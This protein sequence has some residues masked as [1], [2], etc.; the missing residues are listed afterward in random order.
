MIRKI[1]YLSFI[2]MKKHFLKV[3][4]WLMGL[5][6]TLAIWVVNA[7]EINKDIVLQATSTAA[8]QTLKI[9]KY[10][11][12]A[13]T[14][15]RWDGSSE[16]LSSDTTHTYATAWTYTITLS[17]TWWAE[18]RRFVYV[19]K[20][21]VPV[22]WTTMTWVKITSMPSL[23]EWFG[24][25]ATNPENYY[26]LRFNADWAITSLPEWSFDTSSITSANNNFFNS[27]NWN[28]Q[29]TS[30]PTWSFNISN[31]T[32]VGT[33]FFENFNK[34][35]SLTVLP[36]WSFDISNITS[37]N[38]YFFYAFNSQ[39][40]LTSLPTW[41]FKLST[42]LTTVGNYFFIL[43][44]YKWALTSLP[45]WSF[46]T[47]NISWSVWSDF[48]YGFNQYWSL[49]SLPE[50]SFNT[51]NITAAGNAFFR[52]FN[53]YWGIKSLPEWSFNISNLMTVWN[54][55]FRY[56]NGYWALESLPEWSFNISN[57]T[58]V[59]TGLFA[60]FNR[61]WAITELPNSF[62]MNSAW[63]ANTNG[64]QNAFNST[65]Y[66][67]N[68]N[69]SDLVSWVTVP[70]SDMDTF[71]DN[72]PWRCGVHENWLVTIADACHIRYDANGWNGS[73]TWWYVANVT[74]V[75]AWSWIAIPIR[76]GYIFDWWTNASWDIVEEVSFP[77]MDGQTLYA[78]WR[79]KD[80]I[81]QATSTAANQKIKINKYFANNYT[82]NRWDGSSTTNASSTN[83][84]TY[85]TAW[86]Y[87]IT[88]SLT[89]WADR[90][91]FNTEYNANPLVPTNGTTMTWVKIT[92]MP[93]LE[94]WFGINATA[95]WTR[96]F[97]NFN[98]NWALTSLPDWSF[99][100]SKITTAGDGFFDCFNRAWKI[101]S[102][103]DWSFNIS[104][105]TTVWNYFMASFNRFWEMT[106]LPT[107]SFILSSWLT[108]ADEYFFSSFN[109]WW[110][111]TS[112]PEWSF[113]TSNITTAKIYFFPSFNREWA[114]TSLP[115]WS[116]DTSNITSADSY[117]F[118]AFNRDWALTNLPDSFNISSK[119]Y[120]KTNVY[121][122]A[123]N[124][125]YT[126]NKRVYDLVNGKTPPSSDQ[127]TFSDN[128]PW[129]CGVHANWLVTT[130]NACNIRYDANGWNGSV[131]WWYAANTTS[132]AAWSGIT[133]PT[134]E[135]YTFSGWLDASW[136]KVD[137]IVFPDMDGQTLYADWT[138]NE[139]TI[140]FID[141]S[142]TETE[143]I[144]TW[145]YETTVTTDYPEWTKEWYTIHWDKG[146]PTTM[147]LSW[148]TITASW[149]I[150][151][152]TITID[153]DGNITT[154]T[155]DYGSPITP[156]ANPT[157]NWYKFVGWEPEIPATMPAKDMTIKAKWEKNW[158]SGWWGGSRNKASDAQDSS[159]KVYT[160]SSASEWHTYTQEFQEAYEFAKEK[161]IT[162]M[163]TIQKAD[164]DGKLTR[165]AM[166]KMLSQYAMNV[167][168]QKPD[169]TINNKFN[170]V[171]D[172]QNS[173]YDDW[174]TL[175]YQLW[176]MWQNMPNNRF[177][178]NDEV[179][180]WEFV[181]A[182]SRMLYN[183]SDWEYKSTP[184]YYT[185]HMEKMKEE[186]IITN[187][188]PNMKELRGYVMIM[189]MRSAK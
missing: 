189:L 118:E 170:D 17:L 168:W 90:W 129:R 143:V 104:N 9:N 8:N 178:P 184:K 50:W 42:W 187:D 115:E 100:T 38:E 10:F 136:N 160:A 97:Q 54:M 70:S 48:F 108:V 131:T 142:W 37:V 87:T 20:P 39:W 73:I 172:K 132:V 24:A 167:L 130:A 4:L 12:N 113:D 155:W 21:L 128:Q 139:Y 40:S 53:V 158:S 105:I 138:P 52:Q 34:E 183:T 46:D 106:S 82:I 61:S 18:R 176:I 146:I 22:A 89:W 43:F 29:L 92:S 126:I 83:T 122:N 27:F 150:N 32:T 31:I 145:L 85:S 11:A 13:Y 166:A 28:W 116:F 182:L 180:R 69:V 44:N 65:G 49:E 175:A 159:D 156:P 103:P 57:I 7:Q 123:F 121:Y 16:T 173:D 164:M 76:A 86:T 75:V 19:T 133:L 60:Y 25:N 80:I 181:T 2:I 47:S 154:I 141:W 93:S 157:K 153:V 1:F 67:I 79:G 77:E 45:E 107:W 144:Y 112:L 102:I 120:N 68:R 94:E 186:W 78:K 72:Q 99:D 58:T 3:A 55:A 36:E 88:L 174:V 109:W 35:W 41:S 162:T 171:T 114:L 66:T 140:V 26:F 64:Y 169:E 51:S 91:T 23:A 111:L 124:S 98:Y 188:D 119:A 59:W 185:H 117:F 30:L 151:Q 62:N 149:E 5:M 147:P 110:A 165:I 84:H 148:E 152:Y 95:P 15:N 125:S 81:L 63:A 179:T 135:W 127:N 177:R 96:F 33:N 71:S 134:R 137:E 56:F 161:W 101:T 6:G 163:P 74:N 14:V